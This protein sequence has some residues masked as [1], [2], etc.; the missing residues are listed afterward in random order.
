M[1]RT[2]LISSALGLLMLGGCYYDKEELLYP[3]QCDPGDATAPGYW[4]S[5][6]EPI[7][8]ARCAN[9]HYPGGLAPGDLRQYATVRTMV[10]N[11]SF[12]QM[13][14]VSRS[15][16]QGGALS[17]CDMQKLRAWVDAGAPN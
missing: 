7:I 10:D 1:R 9:C 15:M 2:I 12:N 17:S 16:P 14:F 3:G 4:A 11:G 6:I 5:N 8:T 13:V